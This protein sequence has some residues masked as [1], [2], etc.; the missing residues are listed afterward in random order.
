M[1]GLHPTSV[2][3]NYMQEIKDISIKLKGE[4][5]VAIG[6]V[7]IDLYWDKSKLSEQIEAFSTQIT[8]ALELDLPLVIHSRE[9]FPEV[10]S[11]L[12]RFRGTKMKGVFHAFS[13]TLQDAEKAIGMGF[14]LGIG[15]P[16]TFKNS[17]IGSIL[18]VIGIQNIV[19]ETDSPY[20]AP[21]PYRGKRNE[22]SYIRI[23]NQKIAEIFN[24]S[25]EKSASVTFGN[26]CSLF[27]I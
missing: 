17:K 20:L 16:V 8:M 19:L 22:S 15:G 3:E 18:E 6:E 21:M 27:N 14:M 25:E 13:G 2:H 7:G 5:I 4:R 26:S 23:I 9:S 12:D 10:F 11:T 1:L 24:I